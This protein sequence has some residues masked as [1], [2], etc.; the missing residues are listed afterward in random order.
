MKKVFLLALALT[1]IGGSVFSEEK[2]YATMGVVEFGGSVAYSSS[3]ET[4]KENGEEVMD[5]TASR[6]SLRPEIG[7]FVA[8]SISVGGMI[9]LSSSTSEYKPKVGSSGKLTTTDTTFYLAPK[10]VFPAGGTAPGMYPYLGLLLGFGSKTSEVN[11][12]KT[13]FSTTRFGLGGGIKFEVTKGS[14]LDAGLSYLMGS[15]EMKDDEKYKLEPSNLLRLHVGFT[16]Y[17]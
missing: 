17:M 4:W 14:L 6:F 9:E 8:D 15:G 13:T 5:V 3:T 1:L 12:D 10:Y 11:G 2:K 16:L 7:Y